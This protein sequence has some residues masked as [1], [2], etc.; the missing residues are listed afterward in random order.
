MTATRPAFWP[1]PHLIAHRGAGTLAPENTLAAFRLGCRLGFRMMEFDVKLSA[2]DQAI[3][4][5]DDTLERTSS[6]HGAVGAR[7]LAELMTLDFG[8]WHSARFAGE[9]IATLGAVA[10]YSRAQGLAGNLEIK[11]CAGQEARTGRLVALQARALWAGAAL[12]PLLS[13]FSEAALAAAREAAPELPRALLIDAALPA[14]WQYRLHHLGCGGLNLAEAQL[15]QEICTAVRRS[16]HGLAAW[17][18]N[19]LPRARE[20]LRWGCHAIIT[21]RVQ[22]INP[23]TLALP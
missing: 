13:S 22:Q 18:V 14:D 9:P 4:L 11:P 16:G 7:S 17:T 20:L 23:L 2:D 3:L 1:W 6:G 19:S 5:H 15:T 12:P 10:R 8:A 21:D